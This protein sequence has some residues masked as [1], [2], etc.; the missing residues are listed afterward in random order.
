MDRRVICVWKSCLGLVPCSYWIIFFYNT[1]YVN[2]SIHTSCYCPSIVCIMV[3]DNIVVSWRYYCKCITT[4]S[5]CYFI[6][7]RLRNSAVCSVTFT[8]DHYRRNSYQVLAVELTCGII[9]LARKSNK[10]IWYF[11]TETFNTPV[12]LLL[13]LL[14]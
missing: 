7:F 11:A 3:Y 12:Y 8:S 10:N 6:R 14:F 13:L 1:Y 2:K 4:I 9:F 5:E